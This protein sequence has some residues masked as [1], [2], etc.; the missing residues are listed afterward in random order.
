MK[1][2][3]ACRKYYLWTSSFCL[4]FMFSTTTSTMYMPGCRSDISMIPL[5][6]LS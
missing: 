2:F 4:I 6:G 5:T 1:G 3:D